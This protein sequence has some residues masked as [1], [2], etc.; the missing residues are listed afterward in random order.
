M[1]LVT[2]IFFPAV[3]LG[4]ISLMT[5]RKII[6]PQSNRKEQLVISGVV[7]KCI[8]CEIINELYS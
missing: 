2:C 4:P 3:F 5:G 8:C 7:K 6:S 1:N